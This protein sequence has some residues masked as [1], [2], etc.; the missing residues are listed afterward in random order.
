MQLD[1]LAQMIWALTLCDVVWQTRSSLK[2]KDKGK[3]K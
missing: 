1:H 3:R 2:K